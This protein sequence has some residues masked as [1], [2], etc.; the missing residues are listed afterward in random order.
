MIIWV[1]GIPA[2]GKTCLGQALSVELDADFIDSHKLRE[3]RGDADFSREGRR[4]NVTYVAVEAALQASI[5][6][7]NVVV[8][9]IAPY[10][11]DRL[12]AR[13][14]AEAV[15]V[16]FFCV[17]ARCPLSLAQTRDPKGIYAAAKRGEILRLTGLDAPFEEKGG[18]DVVVNTDRMSISDEVAAVLKVVRAC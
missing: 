7:V 9:C 18:F 11:E 12:V 1:A 3:K 2:A 5:A 15:K 4:R 17:H 16:P 14:I 10:R 6:G 8:A 13:Y